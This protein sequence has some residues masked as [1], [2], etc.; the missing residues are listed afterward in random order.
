MHTKFSGHFTFSPP[1]FRWCPS[2]GSSIVFFPLGA[3]SSSSKFNLKVNR[4]LRGFSPHGPTFGLFKNH[5][6]SIG[7][8]SLPC[9]H[10]LTEFQ[11]E[12]NLDFSLNM[13]ML[14]FIHSVHLSVG[15]PSCMVF[16]HLQILFDLKILTNKFSQLFFICFYVDARCIFGNI[17][18]AFGVVRLLTLAKPFGDI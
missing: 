10:A 1:S 12:A 7:F 3:P 16:E 18:W 4:V 2:F 14:A 11:L 15:G 8:S 13:F 6:F 5:C 9:S 17:T